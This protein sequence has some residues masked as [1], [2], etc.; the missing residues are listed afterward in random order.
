MQ[1][2]DTHDVSHLLPVILEHAHVLQFPDVQLQHLMTERDRLRD[3]VLWVGTT[4]WG[5]K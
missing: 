3:G 1:F 2:G 4:H 5:E